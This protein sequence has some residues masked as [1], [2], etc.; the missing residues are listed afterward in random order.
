[1]FRLGT[2]YCQLA[3]NESVN[4]P[5][6]K[7]LVG[8]MSGSWNQRDEISFTEGFCGLI[9][10]WSWRSSYSS[11]SL[12]YISYF[13]LWKIYDLIMF[14][15]VFTRPYLV[16]DESNN[17]LRSLT[18][19]KIKGVQ[20]HNSMSHILPR[21]GMIYKFCS[22]ASSKWRVCFQN[23]PMLNACY[24]QDSKFWRIAKY[25]VVS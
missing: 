22:P 11:Q 6:R 1:M 4:F 8:W 2:C 19:I 7:W 15:S 9:T 21:R 13:L 12:P 25:L 14:I 23:Y 20:N 3:G 17:S 10:A 24:G 16:P 18:F 5:S